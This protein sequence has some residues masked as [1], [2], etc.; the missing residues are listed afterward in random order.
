MTSSVYVAFLHWTLYWL[1]IKGRLDV[2]SSGIHYGYNLT[3][4]GKNIADNVWCLVINLFFKCTE[5]SEMSEAI[6]YFQFFDNVHF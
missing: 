1:M 6:A 2:V 3:W 5:K 4:K